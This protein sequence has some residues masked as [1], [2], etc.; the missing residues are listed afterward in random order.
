L[1]LD[2]LGV[3]TAAA[4]TTPY[5]ALHN[6]A[7][8]KTIAPASHTSTDAACGLVGYP[9]RTPTPAILNGQLA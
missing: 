9:F 3:V 2:I 5:V 6:S 4:V 7:P 8:H 1:L